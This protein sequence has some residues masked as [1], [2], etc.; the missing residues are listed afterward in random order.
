MT[1]FARALPVA[2]LALLSAAAAAP[3]TGP[4][5]QPASALDW[6]VAAKH[7]GETVTITGPVKGTHAAGKNIVLNLGKDFPEK[8]RFTVMLPFDESAGSAD[9]QFVGKTA[10]V[11]GKVKLYK[12]VPEIVT[13]K[14]AD[15]TLTG[16][17]PPTTAPATPA[18]PAER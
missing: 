4:T 15:V 9:D 16:G 13:K 8:D 2:V 17:T 1:R 10:T 3:T 6:S 11:T 18:G 12:G 14:A 5:S 7:V